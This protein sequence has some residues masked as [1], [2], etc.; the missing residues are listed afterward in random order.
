M[1]CVESAGAELLARAVA[2]CSVVWNT[3]ADVS[4]KALEKASVAAA[5]DVVGLSVELSGVAVSMHVTSQ[6]CSPSVHA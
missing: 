3:V 5:E 2:V 4:E 1:S 6:Y